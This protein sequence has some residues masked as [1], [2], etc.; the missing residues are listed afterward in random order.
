MLI[1]RSHFESSVDFFTFCFF[2]S[3]QGTASSKRKKMSSRNHRGSNRRDSPSTKP[4]RSLLHRT[5]RTPGSC[6]REWACNPS[7]TRYPRCTRSRRCSKSYQC[8]HCLHIARRDQSSPCCSILFRRIAS[9]MS[10]CTSTQSRQGST[11]DP[12]ATA[13]HPHRRHRTGHIGRQ[14]IGPRE[15]T[16]YNSRWSKCN[17]SPG[18]SSCRPVVARMRKD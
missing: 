14:G 12:L 3:P 15:S 5:A 1:L 16:R 8:S 4:R 11:A 18:G 6:R 10:W 9:S 13:C 7:N 17:C 2:R